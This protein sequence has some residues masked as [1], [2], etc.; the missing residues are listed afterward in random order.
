MSEKKCRWS[1][2]DP[3][4]PDPFTIDGQ[5]CHHIDITNKCPQAC[6]YCSRGTRHIRPDQR[7][8][9]T[10]EQVET[11]LKSYYGKRGDIGMIGGE[12]L[13]HTQFTEICALYRKYFPREWPGEGGADPGICRLR[14][15]SAAVPHAKWS[16][17]HDVI[18]ETFSGLQIN[19]HTPEKQRRCKHQP[20]TIAVGDV[21][22]K[23]TADK[24][25]D[26]CWVPRGWCSTVNHKGAF[27][28]E[29]A[30]GLDT[31]LDGPGGWP[32]EPGWWRRTQAD[33][34]D[35]RDRWCHLCGMCLPIERQ[36]MC[37]PREKFT[38]ALLQL[39]REHNLPNLS[40]ECVEVVDLKMTAAEVEAAKPTWT[41]WN[42]G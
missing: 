28:C 41:P 6:A 25:I 22:D 15:W 4:C 26:A 19:V 35:Q 1:T 3:W 34:K 39:Y 11:A 21:C 9:M 32:V 17:Y 40:E 27:F 7:F 10:L 23:E 36:I 24:L 5:Y 38:P 13:L 31:I 42:Y 29:V 14:I 8:E 2:S 20:S 12:P 18:Q 33:C 37:S 16:E 30:A